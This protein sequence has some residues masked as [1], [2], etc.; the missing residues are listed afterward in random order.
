MITSTPGNRHP[1]RLALLVAEE[2]LETNPEFV[3]A[4]GFTHCNAAATRI[5]TKMGAPIPA[6]LANAQHEWLG[7][8]AGQAAGFEKSDA[9]EA[10]RLADQGAL[11]VASWFNPTKWK[12]EHGVEHDG[13]G[14]IAI[15]MPSLGEPGI[16]VAAAGQANFTRTQIQHSFG[17]IAPD[18]FVHP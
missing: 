10:Q 8:A 16:W 15:G 2:H 3:P 5:S 14:H 17:P 6:M 18:W 7:S 4:N 11:V 13:H 1:A 9:V 12:D